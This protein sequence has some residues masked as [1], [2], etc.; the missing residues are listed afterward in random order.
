M[1]LNQ[2]LTESELQKLE[3]VKEGPL[4]NKLGTAVGK[5]IGTAAKAVGAVAGGI[6]G[7]GQAVK[8]GYQAGKKTV[9]GGG[10]QTSSPAATGGAAPAPSTSTTTGT[11]SGGTSTGTT[12]TGTDQ[13][14]TPAQTPTKPAASK[15]TSNFDRLSKAAQG[16]DPDAPANQT[17]TPQAATDKTTQAQPSA[18]AATPPTKPAAK[19]QPSSGYTQIQQRIDKLVPEKQQEILALLQ[20]DA[21][22]QKGL[23]QPEAEPA[24]EPKQANDQPNTSAALGQFVQQQTGDNPIRMKT[25]NPK[26]TTTPATGTQTTTTTTTKPSRTRDTKGRYTK[27]VEKDAGW[28]KNVSQ[29]SDSV[30]NPAAQKQHNLNLLK[31]FKTNFDQSRADPFGSN[32]PVAPEQ[33]LTISD[34]TGRVSK[35]YID[36]LNQLDLNQRKDLYNILRKKII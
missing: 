7:I 19:P 32:K 33:D 34:E 24:A 27:N 11:Q 5:G 9:G 22:V 18:P 31:N 30:E 25:D 16:Q 28:Q 35:Y 2:I 8:K 17:N 20:K 15:P 10:D 3:I 13:T 29:F 21:E 36:K 4:M 23:K 12:A 6:A 26:Q 14:Q 1:K